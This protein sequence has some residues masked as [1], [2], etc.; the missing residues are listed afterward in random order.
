MWT[1]V[2]DPSICLVLGHLGRGGLVPS[3][4]AMVGPDPAESGRAIF[5][6]P[7]TGTPD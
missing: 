4:S 1:G 5:Y 3:F 6:F 2:K 7:G